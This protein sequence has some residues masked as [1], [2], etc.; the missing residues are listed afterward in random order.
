MR[1]QNAKEIIIST[2]RRTPGQPLLLMGAP[3]TAKTS[4]AFDV[5]KELHLSASR[6]LLIRPSLRDP[7][8]LLGL[9]TVSDGVAS[10]APPA[11]LYAFREGTGPGLIIWDE[12]PQAVPMMQNAI[13][14]ALLDKVL[15][16]LRLDPA[17][18]QIATGNRT[19]DKAGA[20]RI[21]SQLGN[22]VK[23]LNIEAHL[24]DWCR[25]AITAGID[26]L[27]I[28]FLRL[29]PDLLHDF[30]PDRV[31]N[32]TPRSWEQV[33]MSCEPA[34][35]RDIFYW[36]VAGLVGEGA[37]AE[38]VGFRDL[39][40]SMPSVDGILLNPEHAE[41]PS[42]PA[43]LFAVATALAQRAT[44][45]NLGALVTYTARLPAEFGVL[46]MQDAYR[47]SPEIKGCR[48]FVAWAA[49]NSDVFL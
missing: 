44:K 18:S 16:N 2:L 45:D 10:F 49:T 11:D 5:A 42:Q 34:A 1:Y 31:S 48:A 9:P 40:A 4:L 38:Y 30:N 39:A 28:A 15:G 32:S 37:A 36:D 27:L 25:W 14:G 6:V 7:V 46:F 22:R 3:G 23:T 12:L 35:P 19:Q 8:D 21:M 41:V 20:G 47:R 29:R 33:S 43:V 13:A 17:V 26:P 24:D